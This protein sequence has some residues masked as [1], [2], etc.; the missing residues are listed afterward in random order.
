MPGGS[1]ILPLRKD[2]P[3]LGGFPALSCAIFSNDES[4][5]LFYCIFILA[6]IDDAIK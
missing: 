1:A 5:F 3:A 4:V 2:L 6:E